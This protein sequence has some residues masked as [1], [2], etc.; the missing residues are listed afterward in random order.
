M[1][2][3]RRLTYNER[4]IVASYGLDPREYGCE[5][6]VKNVLVL[7]KHLTHEVVEVPAKINDINRH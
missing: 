5:K 6:I 7:R 4:K 2:N 3:P 1:K